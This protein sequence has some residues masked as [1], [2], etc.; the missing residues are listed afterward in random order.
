M[1]CKQKSKNQAAVTETL[2]V[3]RGYSLKNPTDVEVMML[4]MSQ[5]KWSQ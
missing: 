4:E 1:P 2:A 3:H 5:E